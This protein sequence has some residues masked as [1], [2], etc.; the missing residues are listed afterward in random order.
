MKELLSQIASLTGTLSQ[1]AKDR[2]K[3]PIL[4][5]FL[6][7]WIV[8]NWIPIAI[9]LFS[10]ASIEN[11]IIEITENHSNLKHLLF[12]PLL[13]AFFLYVILPYLSIVFELIL[14]FP[15]DFNQKQQTKQRINI[16]RDELDYENTE[17]ELREVSLD[18][19]Q[20]E[21][22]KNEI[23]LREKELADE[24]ER[25]K[26]LLK[27]IDGKSYDIEVLK[28][29][30]MNEK[31]SI[32]SKFDNEIKTLENKLIA[33]EQTV[34]NYTRRINDNI[35]YTNE[36]LKTMEEYLNLGKYDMA[37]R[38]LKMY[39]QKSEDQKMIPNHG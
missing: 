18:N 17:K 6:F 12:Y 20:I 5:S 34:E 21:N 36:I 8:W 33:S 39:K 2:L 24:R 30:I 28:D 35:V 7:S 22:F 1:V 9:F 32:T 25:N 14:S 29:G 16:L 23:S 4:A 3:N 37:T 13:S 11:R 38:A 27:E 15:R 10:N 26:K 19:R 31:K